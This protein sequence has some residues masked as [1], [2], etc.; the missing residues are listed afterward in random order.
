MKVSAKIYVESESQKAIL[1]GRGGRMVKKIGQSARKEIEGLFGIHTFLD[2]V[3]RVEKN[4][5]KDPK[6]L[7]RL[8]Y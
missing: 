8:G 5:S 2:L 3:V 1:I 4:W 7:K 6:A